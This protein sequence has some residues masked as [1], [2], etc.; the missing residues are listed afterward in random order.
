M[1]GTSNKDYL[2][3]AISNARNDFEKI[4]FF[5]TR[6]A[7]DRQL[8][9]VERGIFQRLLTLGASL[10]QVFLITLGMGDVGPTHTDQE[11][12]RRKRHGIKTRVYQSVFGRITIKRY[13]YWSRAVGSVFPLDAMLNLPSDCYSYLLQEWG[14][15][16]GVQGAWGK[17]TNTLRNMLK[18]DLWTSSLERISERTSEDVKEFYDQH[19]LRRRD[20]EGGLLVATVDGKGVPM[21]KDEP[22]KKKVRLKK[23][24]KP[25]KKKMATVTGLYTIDRHDRKVDDIVKDSIN[26]PQTTVEEQCESAEQDRPKPKNKIV[27]AT[28]EGKKEAFEDLAQ[29]VERRDPEGKKKRV[30]LVDGEH[31]LRALLTQYLPGFCIILDLYHVLEYFWKAVYVIHPEGSDAATVWVQSMLKLLLQGE[32]ENI[33]TYLK[34]CRH[35]HDLSEPNK[36]CLDTVIGY[37]ENGKEFMRYDVYLAQG[38][39]IGS[40][41]VEGACKNLVKGRMELSGMRWTISGAESMLGIRSISVNDLDDAFW[42]YRVRAQRDRLYGNMLNGEEGVEL[43]VA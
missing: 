15:L 1:N 29:Q 31:K 38:Y 17:V 43:Q 20:D 34:G 22:T 40:G 37:L 11:G 8:H 12:V 9:E 10:L 41:V 16:L 27:K 18:L 7:D 28:L 33:I 3:T 24:E 6:D 35:H 30:A 23:G 39:P 2:D 21:K 32:I 14:M 13:C 36:T 26:E 19:P 25:G 4:L 42:S 5:V